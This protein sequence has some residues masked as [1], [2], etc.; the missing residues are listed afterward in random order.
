MYSYKIKEENTDINKVVIEKG[1]IT[2]SFTLADM[3][4]EQNALK[5]YLKEFAANQT[6]KKTMMD[7]VEEYH[8]FVKDFTDEQLF[9]TALYQQAKEAYTQYANKIEEFTKQLKDSEAETIEIIK[10]IG[11]STEQVK[12]ASEVIE[13]KEENE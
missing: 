10:Q 5:K 1:N 8:P 11:V 4:E 6:V 3:T 12:E 7:N 2:H 9:T 13:S